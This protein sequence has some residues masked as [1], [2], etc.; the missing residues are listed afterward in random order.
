[1]SRL[2]LFKSLILFI[3]FCG[4]ILALTSASE[5]Q[6]ANKKIALAS[7]DAGCTAVLLTN[8]QYF[9]AL[10]KTV[11]EAKSEIIMSFFLFKA[12]VRKSSY[13]DRLLAQ[14][15]EAVKRGVK[16]VVILENS[17]GHDRTLDAENRLTKELLE[18]NGVEV[19][20]D[21]PRKTTHTKVVVIDQRF[22]L[23][24]SHNL[25]QAALKHNNEISVLLTNPDLAKEAR[26]Y[27]Q[28]IIKEAK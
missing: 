18:K 17:G 7:D 16:V 26:Q 27:M 6:A 12:G 10:L 1:M 15:A 13:P 9:P 14:L 11:D 19:Y 22:I 25:T 28:K 3:C 20:L 2:S 23:L 24:G 21:S 8:Q 5:V 4:L